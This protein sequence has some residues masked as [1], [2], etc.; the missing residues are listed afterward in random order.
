VIELGPTI[1]TE[2]LILRPPSRVDFD[3]WAA[4]IADEQTM[5]FLGGVQPRFGA[6]RNFL[7]GAGS[8]AVQGFG[9]F[10]VIETA[11]GRWI[12]RVGPI[13][14]DGWPGTEIGWGLAR[15]A[16]GR[17]YAVEAVIASTNWAVDRLGWSEIIHC[18]DADNL[19]SQKVAER[20]GSRR[21]GKA[22]LPPPIEH[23]EV[24]V[25]GQTSTEWRGMRGR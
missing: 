19:A 2:R 12:G 14:Y 9:M 16:W 21:L 11:S 22:V 20:L 13:H 5:R 18:I 15:D 7:G 25:W 6:W 23:G 8:W 1:R 4:F 3:A 24:D 10:S 17:G